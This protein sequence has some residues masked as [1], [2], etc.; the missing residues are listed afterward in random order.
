MNQRLIKS[1]PRKLAACC[2][3][4]FVLCAPR[5]LMATTIAPM[6]IDELAAGAE[7]VFEGQVLEHNVQEN[8]AGIIVTYVT[9][10]V[11]DV[12]KGDYAEPFLELKF[13]GGKLGGEVVEVSGLRIPALDEQGIYFVESLTRDLINPLLGWSQGHFLVVNDNGERRVSTVTLQA[14]TDV[15]SYESVPS[16]LRRPRSYVDGNADSATGIV[17]N[18]MPFRFERALTVDEFKSRIRELLD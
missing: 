1:T 3:A 4:L 12:V 7:F 10:Q 16:S 15:Q 6:D 11:N 2:L 14:V 9:F 8:A 5:L 18:A 13:T 17:T